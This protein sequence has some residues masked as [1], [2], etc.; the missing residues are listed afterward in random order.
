MLVLLHATDVSVW[1]QSCGGC[2]GDEGCPT[3][4]PSDRDE[5]DPATFER[6]LLHASR[7]DKAVCVG[8]KRVAAARRRTDPG[9][10]GAG[11]CLRTGSWRV[12][13]AGTTHP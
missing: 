3:Q 10:G 9:G 1:Q 5:S 4:R 12:A 11:P 2:S 13:S 6:L 8:E 7:G